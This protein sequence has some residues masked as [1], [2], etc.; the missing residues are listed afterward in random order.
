MSINP[1][2]IGK[3]GWHSKSNKTGVNKCLPLFVLAVFWATR[4][5]AEDGSSNDP[6][7]SYQIRWGVQIPTRDG[8]KLNATAYLPINKEDGTSLKEPTIVMVTPYV[9]DSYHKVSSYFA[10]RGYGF[11]LVDCRGRGNSQGSFDPFTNDADDCYDTIEWAAQQSFCNGKIA[12]WGGSYSGMNQWLV[13]AK[14]APHLATIAP[15]AAA[16]PGYDFPFYRSQPIPYNTQWLTLVSGVTV[17]SDLFGDNDFWI[18]TFYRAY[19][20]FVPF[21]ELDTFL[22]NAS[23]IFQKWLQHPEADAFWLNLSPK[24][25]EL[26]RIKIPILS[27]TGQYDADE[28]GNLSYYWQYLRSGASGAN[29]NCY[30]V[31]GPWDHAGTRNPTAEVGGV[32]FGPASVLDVKDLHRRWWDWILKLGPK[33]EFLKDHV[34]YYLLGP[35]NEGKGAWKYAPSLESVEKS[36]LALFLN[37]TNGAQTLFSSGI[38]TTSLPHE[39]SDSY[40]YDPL[41]LRRGEQ[42]EN[43]PYKE[44]TTN[45]DQRL[46]CSINGD[47][48]IY[49]TDPLPEELCVTGFPTLSLWLSMD[50]PDTDVA[51]NLYEVLPDGVA[52]NIWSDVVRARYRESEQV[53]KLVKIGEVD[54]YYFDPRFFV[55]RRLA[56]GSRLRL[57]VAAPNS[58]YYQKNYNSGQIVAN[59]TKADARI[60]H[61]VLHHEAEHPSQLSIPIGEVSK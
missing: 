40:T 41:D 20:N 54:R 10:Q 22:G 8:T 38:L 21:R 3:S 2:S 49:Q 45:I 52:I 19:R 5:C 33:P 1:S 32:K 60:A 28:Y 14:L 27:I 57:I 47:G 61:V 16:R 48:L 13:A 23:P 24:T 15:V 31:V 17:Q 11:L 51:V 50:V 29:E 25:E 59:E 30:L 37:S 46:A 58:I 53:P 7:T 55:A 43:I 36:H 35:G 4:L 34:A 42:V 12:M 6:T 9:S 26:S 18:Q 44:S 56:K 39:G